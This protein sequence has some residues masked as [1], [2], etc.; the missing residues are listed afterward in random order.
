MTFNQVIQTG[1]DE[2]GGDDKAV[3]AM[4]ILNT[5]DTLLSVV[6]DHKE[7]R[8]IAQLRLLF[9][10]SP[11]LQKQLWSVVVF[12][13]T[14]FSHPPTP[15]NALCSRHV[16]ND[17]GARNSA[18][19]QSLSVGTGPRRAVTPLYRCPSSGYRNV[20]VSHLTC[21]EWK[22]KVFTWCLH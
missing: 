13:P 18:S 5:I 20:A 16:Q 12:L 15:G 11:P 2:E 14:H 6:E 7:V 19:A 3:T 9:S 8:R 1:P 17:S 4:G 21:W 10:P 22:T